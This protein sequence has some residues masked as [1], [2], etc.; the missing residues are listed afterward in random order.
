MFHWGEGDGFIYFKERDL[1]MDWTKPFSVSNHSGV[2]V[3]AGT[4]QVNDGTY[5][6]FV[7]PNRHSAYAIELLQGYE[8][9][10]LIKVTNNVKLPKLSTNSNGSSVSKVST[11]ANDSGATNDHFVFNPLDE[12]KAIT[13]NEINLGS[14][15]FEEEEIDTSGK[16]IV[17]SSEK[18]VAKLQM[19]KEQATDLLGLH[20]K[21][22]EAEI[23]KIEDV[24]ALNLLQV[25]AIEISAAEKKQQIIQNRLEEI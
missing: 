13:V 17:V 12:G 16:G 1:K 6:Y 23:K 3:I 10:D 25:V 19:T 15:L 11:A 9:R 20:W 18:S 5:E 24:K 8:R 21:K 22:F 4:I 2:T 7:D 14:K